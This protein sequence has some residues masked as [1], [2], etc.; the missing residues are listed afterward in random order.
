MASVG[1]QSPDMSP[2]YAIYFLFL[3][4]VEIN[5]YFIFQFA[6]C[7]LQMQKQ[8]QSS[9]NALV[10]IGNRDWLI[11]CLTSFLHLLT[12]GRLYGTRGFS[13]TLKKHHFTQQK[14]KLVGA[15]LHEWPWLCNILVK[16]EINMLKI[17]LFKHTWLTLE[18]NELNSTKMIRYVKNHS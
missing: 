3:T 7:K 16:N 5:I 18:K 1:N 13:E 12:R 11:G 17:W 14:Q 9:E 4:I 2:R 15:D 6:N 8:T 10:E